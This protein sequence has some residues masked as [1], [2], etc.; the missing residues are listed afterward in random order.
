MHTH[1]RPLTQITDQQLLLEVRSLVARERE[2]TAQL[3]ASL[4]ELD[5]RK[6]YL[7]EGYSSLF[8]YCTQCL[9]L[10][11]HA[12]YSRIEVARTARKWPGRAAQKVDH[13]PLRK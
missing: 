9:H 2:A 3:I 5:R 13:S 12:A 8:T 10:S 7:G 6:L 1:S 11:E 4:A